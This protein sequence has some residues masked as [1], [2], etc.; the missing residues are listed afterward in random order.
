MQNMKLRSVIHD[1]SKETILNKMEKKFTLLNLK[2][3]VQKDMSR[4]ER[5]PKVLID[6][7]NI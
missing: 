6:I 1:L 4:K 5:K 3:Q 2:S 7:F